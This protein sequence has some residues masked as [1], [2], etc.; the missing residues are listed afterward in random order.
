MPRILV[1]LAILLAIMV[2]AP[3]GTP[4]PASPRVASAATVVFQTDMY[5]S[6]QV[7]AVRTNAWG[8]VR[9]FFNDQKTEADYTV[10]VKGISGNQVSGADIHRGRSGVNGPVVRK[11]ADGGF[12]VAAGHIRFSSA[13]LNEMAG[14]NWYISLK[15]KQFPNGEL[16]GQIVLPEGFWL[17]PAAAP[18]P[19]APVFLP[20]PPAALIPAAAAPLLPP[21]AARPLLPTP[22]ALC[23][24]TA[25]VTFLWTPV[26]GAFE[27]WLDL[28]LV[29]NGFAA[30][31]FGAFGPMS[32]LDDLVYWEGLMPG[33]PYYWRVNSRT[34]AGWVPSQTAAFRACY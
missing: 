9:W 13:D 28:S 20:E 19:P 14:G 32:A 29:D 7:P 10:D 8:F 17:P 33:R 31:T 5:G 3:P 30:G 22:Y 1:A 12:I 27:Q 6:E 18:A 24:E 2:L 15:S 4:G 23:D 16:R 25:Q 26:E 11:L 34:A 21:A